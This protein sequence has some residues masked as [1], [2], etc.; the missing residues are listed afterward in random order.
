MP[1]DTPSSTADAI[2][3]LID[4]DNIYPDFDPDA[5]PA[6]L[7]HEV[8]KLLTY[9]S[10]AMKPPRRLDVRLY[11]GWMQDGLLSRKGSQLQAVASNANPFPLAV[12]SPSSIVHGSIQVVTSMFGLPTLQWL[13]TFRQ[14]TGL[15][16]LRL[17]Q[18]P[19]PAACVDQSVSCPIKTLHS[20]SKDRQRTCSVR[21]CGVRSYDA[22]ICFEQKMVDTMMA[23]DVLTLS[24]SAEITGIVVL[25]D[26]VDILPAIALAGSKENS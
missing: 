23:C 6:W 9:T 11:G 8:N 7:R 21:S 24:D 13:S 26:D 17:S 25:T 22:F 1:V 16:R 18:S 4:F 5:D 14:R 19:Y 12:T 2:V 15:P 3:V 20:I 10:T